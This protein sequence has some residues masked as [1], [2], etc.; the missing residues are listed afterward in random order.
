M[1]NISIH[2][3]IK[4]TLFIPYIFACLASLY[5][6][7]QRNTIEYIYDHYLTRLA[8]NGVSQSCIVKT[9]GSQPQAGFQMIISHGEIVLGLN[10]FHM[11]K[12]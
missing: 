5:E 8:L 6:P 1:L 2:I 12:G 9:C 7:L 11:G 3:C 4:Y 10:Y